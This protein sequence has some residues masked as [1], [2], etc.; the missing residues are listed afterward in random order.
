MTEQAFRYHKDT[1]TASEA[2]THCKDHDGKFEAATT[3]DAPEPRAISQEALADEMDFVIMAIREVGI[4]EEQMPMAMELAEAIIMRSTGN[5]IPDNILARVGTV[6]S[7]K[8]EESLLEIQLRLDEVLGNRRTIEQGD[9]QEP[10]P[11]VDPMDSL[12]QRAIDMAEVANIVVAKLKGKR[13]PK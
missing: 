1:W 12:K 7:T 6:L 9:Q 4:S 13:I 2:R 11:E 5:D 10:L 3:K 8:N